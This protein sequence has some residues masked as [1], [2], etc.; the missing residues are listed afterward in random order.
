[1]TEF[2]YQKVVKCIKGVFKMAYPALDHK[3][4]VH[5]REVYLG[6][7]CSAYIFMNDLLMR[8]LNVEFI[9][10]QMTQSFTLTENVERDALWLRVMVFLHQDVTL[11]C[12]KLKYLN[13]YLMKCCEMWFRHSCSAK[14]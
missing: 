3:V 7:F 5:Q 6:R 11:M 4:K 14:H 10:M 13:K 9:C 1:M 8:G 2:R 12:F